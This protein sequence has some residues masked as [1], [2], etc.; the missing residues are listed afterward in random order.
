MRVEKNNSYGIGYC[1]KCGAEAAYTEATDDVEYDNVCTDPPHQLAPPDPEMDYIDA[2]IERVGELN[3]L[4]DAI[5]PMKVTQRIEDGE[6]DSKLE[7]FT[8]YMGE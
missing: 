1:F 6:D 3:S 2:V 4:I 7:L 8:G 5:D